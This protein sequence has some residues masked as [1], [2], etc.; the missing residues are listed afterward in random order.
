MRRGAESDRK[1]HNGVIQE[2][3][4]AGQSVIVNQCECCISSVV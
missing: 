1:D 2:K 4:S 3:P